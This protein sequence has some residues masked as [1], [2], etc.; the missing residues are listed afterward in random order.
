MTIDVPDKESAT[1]LAGLTFPYKDSDPEYAALE[2]GNYILGGSFTSRIWDRLR[3][4]EGLCYG[5]GTRISVDSKD[6]YSLFMTFAI[7]NPV[8]ID[9]V[10]K[11]ALEEIAKIVKN[12]VTPEELEAAKKGYLEELKVQRASDDSIRA[13]LRAGLY[14][15]RTLNF[16][17]ELEKKIAALTLK[18]VNQALSAHITPDRL[19]IIRAGDFKKAK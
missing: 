15:G 14:L 3:E 7:C 13:T 10:N 1:Y 16:E 19:V 6:P 8:N 2:I 11:G 12:G 18:D 9:K 17:I 5:T 4:K